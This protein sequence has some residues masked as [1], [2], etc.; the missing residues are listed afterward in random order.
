MLTDEQLNGLLKLIIKYAD[1]V[2]TDMSEEDLNKLCAKLREYY[3]A[4]KRA[5]AG[6]TQ[7][8]QVRD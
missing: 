4:V 6:A 7:I 3:A 5:E 2:F 8:R 1:K